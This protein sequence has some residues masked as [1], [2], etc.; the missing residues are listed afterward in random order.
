MKRGH[1]FVLGS[2]IAGLSIAELL[3]RNGWRITLLE[4]SAELGGDASRCTQNWLHTGWLY[5]ALPNRAAMLAC[6]H[7]LRLFQPIYGHLLS[8]DTL[9]VEARAAGVSYPAASAG[10]FASERVHYLYATATAE[11][12]MLQRL[13]WKRHL[14]LVAFRRLRRLGYETAACSTLAPGLVE[15]LNYWEGDASGHSKYTVVRS[16]DAQINTRRVLDTLLGLLGESAEVVREAE[17]SLTTHEQ[18][19]SLLIGGERHT[20]DLLVLATG[21]SVP[22][23]LALLDS[24]QM[25]R[26]FKSI[27]SPIVVL[28]RA[29]E[30]P[31]FIRFTPKLPE[32]INH[33]K[34]DVRGVG[35]RSTIGSYEYYPADQLPDISPF[36]N[37]VC[38]RLNL[39]VSDV[40][41]VYYGTKT[42]LTGAG[43]RRYNHAIE[44]VNANTFCAIPGKFSQFPLLVHE[45]A[46]RLGLR[47]DIDAPARG[48]L[49]LSASATLP[50]LSFAAPLDRA[51][52]GTA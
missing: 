17:Y 14:E 52:L 10:W 40:A 45:F 36:I 51:R 22:Q 48:R 50:E 19:S 24:T 6:N 44:R 38:R 39:A 28:K 30:L 23:Q 5:A 12:S 49:R 31:N 21:K 42:E 7:A 37:R 16:T 2:G 13:G 18:R 11:L 9:N 25:A 26:K 34:Y 4:T 41:S 20:P 29:L 32:T 35:P 1:A 47:T 33:I 3:S 43:E 46:A 15:L 27:C 8:P